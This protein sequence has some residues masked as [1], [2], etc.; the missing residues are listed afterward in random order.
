MAKREIKA[1]VTADTK[2]YKEGLKQAQEATSKLHGALDRFGPVG[3]GAASLLEK[4]GFS[5]VSA[6]AGVGLAA[7]AVGEAT[8]IVTDAIEQWS[9]FV[10]KIDDYQDV[11][12]QS[13]EA[14]SRQVVAFEELGV[15]AETAG[16]GMFKLSQE[17]AKGN[18]ELGAYGIEV[19][20]SKDGT[21][22]LN[23]TL[24]NIMEA[25]QG[26]SDAA[27]KNAIVMAAFGKSGAAMIPILETNTA[28]LKRLEAQVGKV[29]TDQDIADV[30]EYRIAQQ[31]LKHSTDE[32]GLSLGQ[33]F[34]PA[35]KASV[36]A[37][38][39]N[40]YVQ[41]RL[42]EDTTETTKRIANLHYVNNQLTQSLKDEYQAAKAAQEQ[43]DRNAQ[44]L[45][46]A[47]DAAKRDADAENA[48]YDAIHKSTDANF[49]YRQALIDLKKA[50]KDA[51]DAKGKDQ[52]A[53]LRLE[54]SYHRVADAAVKMADEQR[55]ANGQVALSTDEA[56]A[57]EIAALEKLMKGMAKDSPLYKNL[58]AY[59]ALLQ[60]Q[61]DLQHAAASTALSQ[62]PSS[63][64]ARSKSGHGQ[65]MDDGGTVQGPPGS[66]QPV[67]ARGGEEFS[68]YP[69]KSG[70]GKEVHIHIHGNVIDGP[71]MDRFFREGLARA[72]ISSGM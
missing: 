23:G 18:K 19:V 10:G 22:D 65:L 9:E 15:S 36:E 56:V 60:K 2:A 44:T 70:G 28:E 1:Y 35:A 54:E 33:I 61:V 30:R 63:I 25:Y 20:K 66:L 39:E 11:T 14:S 64:L 55:A 42:A 52:E 59:I 49:A 8:K 3:K 45:N 16:A 37:I 58:Q 68:G 7:V 43:L 48:L 71:A 47:A 31:E 38:N 26:T 72:R 67:L 57:I 17:I 34:L 27:Q 29:V 69:P 50:Q 46:A 41:K 32:M 5:S 12:G 4:M 13:A 51:K 24:I 40:I 6:A 53:N 62:T 21:T